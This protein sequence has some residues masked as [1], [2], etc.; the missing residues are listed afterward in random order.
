MR[1]WISKNKTILCIAAIVFALSTVVIVAPMY[2]NGSVR[3][4]DI[5]RE[6]HETSA[7]DGKIRAKAKFESFLE[8]LYKIESGKNLYDL[9]RELKAFFAESSDDGDIVNLPADGETAY[10]WF[11]SDCK[12][13]RIVAEQNDRGNVTLIAFLRLTE[14]YH[15]EFYDTNIAICADMIEENGEWLIKDIP[16]R[17]PFKTILP[18]DR[19]KDYKETVACL[20]A[21]S[22][23]DS[24]KKR[25]EQFLRRCYQIDKE[26]NLVDIDRELL[27]FFSDDAYDEI[28]FVTGRNPYSADAPSSEYGDFSLGYEIV[29]I[30]AEK[31]SPGCVAVAAVLNVTK[32]ETAHSDITV[33]IC[34]DMRFEN[35]EWLI[36]DIP[37]HGEYGEDEDVQI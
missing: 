30:A 36:Y 21:A 5:V 18:Y 7:D 10:D 37:I 17:I 14:T 4:N 11:S 9:D 32:T 34:A 16:L 31:K 29:R 8:R 3:E 6:D 33:V 25:F 28:P 27:R 19:E 23:P 20:D 15:L 26:T 24:A 1:S 22:E 35:D 2:F 13:K 12:I